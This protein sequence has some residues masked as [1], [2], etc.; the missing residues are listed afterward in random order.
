M[1]PATFEEIMQSVVKTRTPEELEAIMEEEK[2][3]KD[4]SRGEDDVVQGAN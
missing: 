1:L 3:D 2:R 4:K